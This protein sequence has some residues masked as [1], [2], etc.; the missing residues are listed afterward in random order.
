MPKTNAKHKDA[1]I[2]PYQEMPLDDKQKLVDVF[3][4]LIQED[5]KQNPDL[6]PKTKA[7]NRASNRKE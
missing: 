4:W 5:R 6:Y 2:S 3:A 7:K 1:G